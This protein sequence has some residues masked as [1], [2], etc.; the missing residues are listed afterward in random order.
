MKIADV[1]T[2]ALRGATDDHGWPGGTDPNV[3]YNTLVEVV[4]DEGLVGLGSCYTTRALVEGS[5]ALLKE[6][7]LGQSALEP[8]RV[9]ETLRQSMFWLGRGG[10]VE[11]TISGLDIALWDLWGKALGQPVARLLGGSYRDRIKPYASILFDDPPV[12]ADKLREQLAR[13]F[14]AI[15]MG[16]R[17]FGR[18]S[19]KLDERLVKTARETVGDDVEL[20]VDAGGSEQFWPHGLSWARETAKM[21]GDYGV[22]WFEEALVPDDT[23]GFRQLRAVSPVLV[24]TGEVLT[25]RQSFQPLITSRAVDIIQPDLTKCGGLT[26]GLRL[27][28]MAAE[29]GVLLVPHG[30]N[31]A[32]GVAADLALSAAM[33]VARWVE[34]QTGVP[35]IEQLVLPQ[36]K[37]DDEGYLRVPTGP[38]LG[39]EL[40]PDALGKFAQR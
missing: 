6:H 14:R 19:R 34:F 13:G 33:P 36:F 1:R 27:A 21:L 29:H 40:N 30:W 23:E 26:E 11:H 37:L 28:W 15:K 24:A 10:S 7:L 20:M 5:L 9:S 18:V 35:Y 39:I 16:W 32:V 2:I 17:P 8:Q 38:G 3:Q 4:S 25:R 31:T 22:V 12:L